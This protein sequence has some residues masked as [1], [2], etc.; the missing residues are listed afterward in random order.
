MRLRP[1]IKLLFASGYFE[2]AL[3]RNGILEEA[4]NF[5]VKPY[6][7]ADLARKM[8]GGVV[9]RRAPSLTLFP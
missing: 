7:K 3:Q 5:I 1:G 9:W 4:V 2:G 6:K 8:R